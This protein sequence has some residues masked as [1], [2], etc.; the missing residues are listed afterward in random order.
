MKETIATLTARLLALEACVAGLVIAHPNKVHALG[1]ME[2]IVG[3]ARKSL[4]DAGAPDT[5]L[6]AFQQTAMAVQKR[7]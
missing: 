2:R 5:Q 4:L 3:T 6:A 1:Q 7:T